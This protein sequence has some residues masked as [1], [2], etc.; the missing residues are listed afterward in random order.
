MIEEKLSTLTPDERTSGGRAEDR[1]FT[2]FY[3]KLHRVDVRESE[4]LDALASIDVRLAECGDIAQLSN[5]PDRTMQRDWHKAPSV[6]NCLMD[7][8]ASASQPFS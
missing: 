5:V 7:G 6:R 4:A 2:V 3:D 8:I 1:L